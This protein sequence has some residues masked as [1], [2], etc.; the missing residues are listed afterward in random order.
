MEFWGN[1]EGTSGVPETRGALTP[2][3]FT[4][5][6]AALILFSQAEDL[7]ARREGSVR[8]KVPS[9]LW[10][11]EI[12]DLWAGSGSEQGALSKELP[13]ASPRMNSGNP[14]GMRKKAH[15]LQPTHELQTTPNTEWMWT[16]A[17]T[18]KALWKAHRPPLC[19][20]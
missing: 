3:P 13:S 2:Y 11:L 1:S 20:H 18:Q 9:P 10:S 14:H 12:R 16:M 19:P 6:K 15:H 4:T 7:Q 17:L 8:V 5:G